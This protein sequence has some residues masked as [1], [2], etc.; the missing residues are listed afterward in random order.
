MKA[1][2]EGSEYQEARSASEDFTS[3]EL[4]KLRI[5]LRRLRYLSR[6]AEKSG[7][8]ASES[9]GGLWAV[10]EAAALE[11]VLSEIAYLEEVA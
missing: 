7:G 6:Q 3:E 5:L 9:G 2:R 4:M 10:Q 8:V 1:P 11:F